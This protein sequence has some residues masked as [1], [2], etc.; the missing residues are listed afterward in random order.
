MSEIPTLYCFTPTTCSRRVLM[1]LTELGLKRDADYAIARVNTMG[2][3]R[4]PEH[5]ARQPFGRIPVWQ[6]GEW[7]LYESRAICEYLAYK[8]ASPSLVPAAFRARAEVA[9]WIS[10]EVNELYPE[11][12][13]V[14]VEKVLKKRKGLGDADEAVVADGR[15]GLAKPL[16]VLDARLRGR[17]FLVGD[18]FTLAD[19]GHLPYL[20]GLCDG[21]SADLIEARPGVA[22]WWARCS[23]RPAWREVLA[24]AANP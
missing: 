7:L 6:E 3:N 23:A 4:T 11:F 18:C 5:L 13:K 2:E 14:Y 9:Q 19:L 1:T 21:G 22:A 12:R 10:V 15:A 17:E 8:H 24:M 16:D 20:Q